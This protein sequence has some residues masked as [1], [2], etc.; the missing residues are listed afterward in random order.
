M[1]K[2]EKIRRHHRKERLKISKISKFESDL[3]KAYKDTAPQ[4]RKIL[5]TF[6]W[7]GAQTCPPPHYR[8]VCLFP[9]LTWGA[10]SSLARDLSLKHLP[11]VLILRRSLQWWRR[12]PPGGTPHM[13]G[14]G[15][16]VVS[17]RGVNFRFWSHLGCLGKTPSY[18]AVKVSF[19][20][21]RE[22]I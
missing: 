7:W 10:I 5:Q 17:L 9:Q 6:V 4:S 13:K 1:D 21:A 22:K 3:L 15:I 16:L 19:R 14:V 18:L 20:V 8:K 11:K 12:I 2:F